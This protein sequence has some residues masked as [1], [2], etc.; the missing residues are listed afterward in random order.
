MVRA[1]FTRLM[2]AGR[3]TIQPG[4]A[5]GMSGQCGMDRPPGQG[6]VGE[7]SWGH[8]RD[9]QEDLQPGQMLFRWIGRGS[10]LRGHLL[11]HQ[12]TSGGDLRM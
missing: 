1:A 10:L 8:P 12:L 2:R 7:V 6:Q 3:R 9:L 4:N 5:V 11:R